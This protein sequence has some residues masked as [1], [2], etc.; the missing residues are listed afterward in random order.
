M[1]AT[2]SRLPLQTGRS[3]VAV[4]LSVSLLVASTTLS[5]PESHAT[6]P[7]VQPPLHAAEPRSQSGG[8]PQELTT[9]SGGSTFAVG[10]VFVAVGNGR[11]QW[12]QGDGT[13]VTTLDTG[14]GGYTTGMDTDAFGRLYVVAYTAH[15]VH[16]F[17]PIGQ[18]LGEFGDIAAICGTPESVDVQPSGDAFVG[19]STTNQ[20]TCAAEVLLIDSSGATAAGWDLAGGADE[21]ALE[22]D[23][24]Q[25][26]YS[27]EQTTIGRFDLFDVIADVVFPRSALARSCSG[28]R[29]SAARTSATSCS[30]LAACSFPVELAQ[31]QSAGCCE[32]PM[33]SEMSA[34]AFR[35]LA[36]C[37]MTHRRGLVPG[38]ERSHPE[39][40]DRRT[41]R[42]NSA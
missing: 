27:Y 24:C 25:V 41:A 5:P 1:T 13:L 31:E 19:Q 2:A 8:A 12:R 6:D 4:L 14:A 40:S 28:P 38:T 18:W 35:R 34:A 30:M 3:V 42:G 16:R 39:S 22:P 37:W 33:V 26:R 21:I 9:D 15:E 32:P 20:V 10:D 11:V 17:N 36:A 29:S 23:G 7:D